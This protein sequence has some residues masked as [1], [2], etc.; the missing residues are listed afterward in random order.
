MN[1]SPPA[2]SLQKRTKALMRAEV[3]ATAITLFLDRGFDETT[4]DDICTAAGLSRRSFFRYFPAK[5]DVVVN[6]VGR[7]IGQGCRHLV[8]APAEEDIWSALRASMDTFADWID[9]DPDHALALLTLIRSSAN[10]R[11]SYLDR[12]DRWRTEAVGIIATR[13][14]LDPSETLYPAVIASASFGAFNAALTAWTTS[15][16]TLDLR[17]LLDESF[18]ALTPH[19]PPAARP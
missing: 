12:A 11:V 14:G 3:A 16:A 18:A 5:E 9:T 17:T 2:D 19:Q 15:N 1:T 8:A 4:V 10:L 13:L 6:L 7:I